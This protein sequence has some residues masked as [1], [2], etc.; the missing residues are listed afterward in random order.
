MKKT[1][2]V[3]VITHQ[4][5][6]NLR[7]CLASVQHLADQMVVVDQQ[8]TD[9][10][11]AIAREF[12]ALI[13]ITPDW[14]GFG[15]QKNRALS[16][17]TSEWVL[18]IDA[19]ERVPAALAKEIAA[20]LSAST[21]KSAYEIPRQSWYC[22]RFIQH[23]GWRPDHVLRLFKR[24]SAAFS[25]DLVHERVVFQG[26]V[27]RLNH[28]LEHYSFRNF[29]QVLDKIDR[30]STASAEQLYRQ[31]KKSSITKAVVHGGW[32]FIRTYIFK[33]ACLD[34]PQGFALAVSN[35]QGTYYRYLKL[36]LLIQERG[37][38]QNAH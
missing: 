29:S 37:P 31:G 34:G 20:V 36:W 26:E 35:A 33:L 23:A 8:S 12:G 15:P 30:Y 11:V 18:S 28:A 38:C 13:D 27:G 25:L 4:E 32:A 14:P 5:G 3:I 17:A 7:D 10:T 22:G 9:E 24:T 21:T 16:L 2:S 1:L 6:H 19:D